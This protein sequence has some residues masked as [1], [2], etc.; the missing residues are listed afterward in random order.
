V[1]TLPLP[2]TGRPIEVRYR[3]NLLDTAGNAAHAATFIRDRLIV[4]DE[5]LREDSQ[6]HARVLLHELLHFVWVR[7]GNGRRFAWENLLCQ[8]WQAGVRGE[9]GWSS[10]WRKK[11]LRAPDLH[12]RTRAWREYCCES[13]CD[14]GAWCCGGSE[15]E[16]T[17]TPRYRNARRA[18]FEDFLDG[19]FIAV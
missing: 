7:A 14:T 3:A 4:L 8:E 6:E 17:L 5:E 12:A 16:L 1:S 9:C 11:R 2:L 18:W 15:K 10:E 19:R 13:F